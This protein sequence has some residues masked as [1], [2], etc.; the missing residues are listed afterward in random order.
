MILALLNYHIQGE[1]TLSLALMV[2]FKKGLHCCDDPSERH[3]KAKNRTSRLD[4]II[5][6]AI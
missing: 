5:V 4:L 2:G 6:V 3:F 1:Y